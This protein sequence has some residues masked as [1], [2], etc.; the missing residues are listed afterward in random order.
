MKKNFIVYTF[1]IFIFS[2]FSIF[3]EREVNYEDLKYN[4]KTELIYAN[5]EKEPFTGIAKDF[6][7]D[8]SLKVEYPHKNGKIEGIIKSYYPN[9][10]LEEEQTY[11]NILLLKEKLTKIL[12]DKY[13]NT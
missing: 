8:N 6:Y 5:D 10:K 3:A 2:S 1:I 7:E 4:E 13:K 9:G 11:K 12:K